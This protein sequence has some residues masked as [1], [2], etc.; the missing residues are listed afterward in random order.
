M[1]AQEEPESKTISA[2][3]M[4]AFKSDLEGLIDE[5]WDL[6]E[7]MQEAAEANLGVT[8][9]EGGEQQ[10]ATMNFSDVDVIPT[11]TYRSTEESDFQAASHGKR[12]RTMRLIQRHLQELAKFPE[13]ALQEAFDEDENASVVAELIAAAD[14]GGDQGSTKAMDLSGG[15]DYDS[16]EVELDESEEEEDEAEESDPE[17]DPVRSRRYINQH[18]VKVQDAGTGGKLGGKTLK[19]KAKKKE[20]GGTHNGDAIGRMKLITPVIDDM[21][22]RPHMRMLMNN[23]VALAA[24]KAGEPVYV[25]KG[26]KVVEMSEA[27]LLAER[28]VLEEGKLTKPSAT[29]R[30]LQKLRDKEAARK[31]W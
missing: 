30:A 26:T 27:R 2:Y 22:L 24:Y 13:E 1:V 4:T 21:A 18:G 19:A 14:A 16:D 7:A 8:V 5:G 6:Q 10:E 25:R 23:H 20:R 9:G 29:Q 31:E 28:K 12:E 11:L 3:A 17:D 15:E